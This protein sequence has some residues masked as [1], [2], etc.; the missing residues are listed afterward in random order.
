MDWT[1]KLA[2]KKRKFKLE[3]DDFEFR[4]SILKRFIK[5]NGHA[6]VKQDCIFEEHK[7]GSWVSRWRQAYMGKDKGRAELTE[8]MI[9]NL[10]TS[11][12]TWLWAAADAR[13]G[14]AEPLSDYM[15]QSLLQHKLDIELSMAIS[16]GLFCGL[17]MFECKN[18]EVINKNGV[19]CLSLPP[20]PGYQARLIPVSRKLERITPLTKSTQTL[21]TAYRRLPEWKNNTG[22]TLFFSLH[23]SFRQKLTRL[24]LNNELINALSGWNPRINWNEENLKECK[25]V[26]DL[27]SYD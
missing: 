5:N 26:I 1:G 4:L 24:G 15:A 16:Y 20:R 23:L 11:H 3:D 7:L 14:I 19:F 6:F 2:P 10:E 13:E 21:S 18:F 25:R 9:D 17:R 27:V 12:P 22:K 8:D